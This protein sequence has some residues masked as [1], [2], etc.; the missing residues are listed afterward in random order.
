MIRRH[1]FNL[2]PAL[3][4]V[5]YNIRTPQNVRLSPC[6]SAFVRWKSEKGGKDLDSLFQPVPITPLSDP[7]GIN[8]GEELTGG[9]LKKEELLKLLNQFYRGE[10]VK[11]LAAEHGL[12]NNLFHKAYVGFRR[13]C[14]ES[15]A[16]PVD[17][18][19]VLSDILQEAGHVDELF[20]YFLRHAKQ[21]FPHL[22]CMEELQKISDLRLP[23]N[24]YPDARAIQRKII[25][26]AGPTN[27][28]KT[29]HALERFL[30]AKSG[31]YCGPLRLLANEV[32]HKSN[33]AVSYM[34]YYLNN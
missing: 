31:V 20:P 15:E 34:P 8:V 33:K 6:L 2:A 24:W 29:Y 5:T 18:H 28:G 21:M 7:D 32:F 9:P 26:H 30:T 10:H 25:Y 11:R 12:N 27:S 17:L 14:V 16:L 19:V 4:L 13:F 1:L 22:D 23:P 3:R